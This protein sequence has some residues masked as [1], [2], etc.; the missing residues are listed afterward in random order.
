MVSL[1]GEEG[2]GISQASLIAMAGLLANWIAKKKKKNGRFHTFPEKEKF[3][4]LPFKPEPEGF[5]WRYSV[6]NL[7]L[8]QGL[9]L[10]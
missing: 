2:F 5:S 3:S 8:P 10:G 9:G 6:F 1:T 7:H 4:F